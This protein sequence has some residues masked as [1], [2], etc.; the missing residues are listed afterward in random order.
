MMG[1]DQDAVW[2]CHGRLRKRE[3]EMNAAVNFGKFCT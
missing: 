3:R 1:F 2:Q